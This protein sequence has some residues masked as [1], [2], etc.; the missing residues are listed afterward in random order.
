M[1]II[2]RGLLLPL[3]GFLLLQ[4]CE[5]PTLIGLED[6]QFANGTVIDTV[7][8]LTETVLVPRTRTDNNLITRDISGSAFI[9]INYR[10]V[11]YFNDPEFG[12]TDARAFTQ[13]FSTGGHFGDGPILDSAVLILRYPPLASQAVYGDTLSRVNILVEEVTEELVDTAEYYSDQLFATGPVIGSMEFTINRTDSIMLQA[14]VKD[15]P[16]SLV[17]AAPQLRIKLDQDR[18]STRLN[19]SH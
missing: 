16:D 18:K 12:A 5:N 11:G 8:I 4:G 1:K 7:S 9:P 3:A 10:A 6:Q 19:Y 13:I 17:E 2:S 15:G 14:I